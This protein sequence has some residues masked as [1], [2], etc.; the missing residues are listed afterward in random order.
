MYRTSR[1]IYHRLLKAEKIMLVPHRNPDADALGSL[2]AFSQF[3]RGLNKNFNAYCAT[4]IA[5]NLKVLPHTS[6]IIQN[7]KIWQTVPPDLIIVF[8]TGDLRHAGIEAQINALPKKA[9]LINIDHHA[10]NEFYGDYNLVARDFSSTTETLYNFFKHNNIKLDQI[11]ATS[12]LAGLITDTDF[13][14]NSAT[15]RTALR[16][17]AELI[18]GGGN[19]KLIK[20]LVFKNKTIAALKLW[21]A[22]LSRIKK[23][24]TLDLV[25]TYLTREDFEENNVPEELSEGISNFL[26]NL[27]EGQASLILKEMPDNKIKGSFRTTNDSTDVGSI[28][29]ALGGGGHKKAAGFILDGP[30]QRAE[31]EVFETIQEKGQLTIND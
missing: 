19:L 20:E 2:S 7:E 25:Y 12:L 3:L 8:D 16:L 26:N 14:T 18:S 27:S 1:Q 5:E 22:A 21:G 6:Q 29:K 24:Q 15:S 13:F 31:R 28:A 11:M 10:T 9:C 30:L 4:E 17:G 23:H